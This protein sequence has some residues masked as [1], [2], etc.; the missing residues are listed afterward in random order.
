MNLSRLFLIAEKF[1]ADHSPT[2]LTAVGVTGTITTAFLTGRA[3]LDAAEIIK[4]DRET[5][6]QPYE[7]TWQEDLKLI[8]KEFIP[9]VGMGALTIASIIFANRIGMRRAAAMAAA[10]SLSERAF[11]EYKENVVKHIGS[12]R[13]E[14]IRDRIAE[15]RIKR[16]PIPSNQ[17]IIGSGQVLCYDSITGRYFQSDMET[18]RKAQNDINHQLLQAMYATLDDFYKILGLPSTKFSSEV[19]WTSDNMLE[20]K[21]SA[22]LSEDQ[23]PCICIEYSS[24]PVR[25]YY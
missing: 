21:F 20:L 10:Y 1:I 14:S 11:A 3:T 16:D 5:A 6:V 2:I 22:V 23:R 7:P 25:D 13:E 19:G 4:E 17:L 8:W 15:D 18:L 24:Y 12:K 9:P